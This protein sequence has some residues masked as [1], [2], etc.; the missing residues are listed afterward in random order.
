VLSEGRILGDAPAES[1][2]ALAPTEGGELGQKYVE[3]ALGVDI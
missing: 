1:P 2:Q 3:A